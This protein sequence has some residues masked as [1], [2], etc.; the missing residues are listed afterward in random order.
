MWFWMQFCNEHCTAEI[1]MLSETK[2]GFTTSNYC[3]LAIILNCQGMSRRCVSVLEKW[4][5]TVPHCFSYHTIFLWSRWHNKSKFPFGWWWIT[6]LFPTYV[7]SLCPQLKAHAPQTSSSARPPCT[8]SPNSGFVMRILTA[9]TGQMRLI[10]VSCGNPLNHK[11]H[12]STCFSV[13]RGRIWFNL[14]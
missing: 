10:A 11:S 13:K 8:A 9:Q 3:Q 6:F 4:M 2:W 5:A 7:L 12:H 1:K 14:N